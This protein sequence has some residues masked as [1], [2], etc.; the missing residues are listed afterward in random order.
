MFSPDVASHSHS[1][2]P[3]RTRHAAG[4]DDTV[5]L[6]QAKRK[7]SAL[8]RDTFEPLNEA[9][10]NENT[11]RPAAES[12]KAPRDVTETTALEAQ[13]S[14]PSVPSRELTLRGGKKAEKRLER[15]AASLLLSS[16][17]FYTVS[18]LPTLP[19]Q[20]RSSPTLPYACVLSSDNGYAAALSHSDAVIWPYAISSFVPSTRDV[21]TFKLPLPPVSANDPLPLASFTA[22]DASGYPGLVVV[23]PKWGKIVY[24]DSITDASTILPGQSSSGVQGTMPSLAAGEVVEEIINAEPAGY[25]LTTS[26]GRVAH[27]TVRDQVGRPAVGVHFLRKPPS[28]SGGA[29]LGSIRNALIGDRR[30]GTLRVKAGA[31]A[32]GQRTVVVVTEDGD[33]EQWETSLAAGDVVKMHLTLRQVLLD[34]LAPQVPSDLNPTLMHF[35]LLDFELASPEHSLSRRGSVASF[36]IITLVSLSEN[37]RTSYYIIEVIVN[38]AAAQVQV[39]HPI[40]C[41]SDELSGSQTRSRPSLSVSKSQKLAF[42]VFEGAVVLF[43]LAKIEESPTSQ[44]LME[45]H[46]LPDPFQDCIRFQD[47]TIYKVLA[48][49]K[50]EYDQKPALLLAIQGFGI[51]RILSLLQDHDDS[52]DEVLQDTVSAKSKIEQAIFFGTM[53]QNPLDLSRGSEDAF[54]AEEIQLAAMAISSEILAST[55]KYLPKSMPSIDQQMKLRA[56]A[57]NDL[58]SHLMKQYRSK[59]SRNFLYQLLWNAEKLAAAQAIWKVEEEIQRRYPIA[60]RETPYLDFCLYALHESRQKYP[61][62]EKGEKDRVRFWLYNSVEKIA[63]LL[64]ELVDCFRELDDMDV[65][66]PMIVGVYMKEAMDLW[67]AAYTAAF[68]FR[69]DNAQLYGLGDDIFKDGILLAG[70]PAEIGHPWT[71]T[72]EGFQ[73]A[74]RMIIDLIKYMDEWWTFDPNSKEGQKKKMPVNHFD[75]KPHDAPPKT[76]LNDIAAKLPIVTELFNRLVSEQVIFVIRRS[77]QDPDPQSRAEAIA[78]V[79]AKKKPFQTGAILQIRKFNMPGAIEL[80]EKKKDPTLL[81]T[82]TT[83]YLR[84]LTLDVHSGSQHT[85]RYQAKIRETQDRAETYY[86]CFGKGWAY[87]NFRHMIKD[88]QLG[89]LLVTAQTSDNKQTYLTWF[90][91]KAAKCG[92]SLS[93]MSWINDVVGEQNFSRAEKTLAEVASTEEIDVWNTKTELS[94]AKLASLAALE[95]QQEKVGRVENEDTIDEYDNKLTLIDMQEELLKHVDAAIGPALDKKVSEDLAMEIFAARVVD[96]KPGFKKLLR[97]ALQSLLSQQPLTIEEMINALTLSDPV[98]FEGNPEDDPYLLGNEFVWAL[99]A[100]ELSTLSEKYKAALRQVIWRRAMIRDDW[101]ILNNTV[102]KSD[103]DVQNGMQQSSVFRT[104]VQLFEEVALDQ[105]VTDLSAVIQH[106]V[107]FPMQILHNSLFTLNMA[108]RF[109]SDEKVREL[110]KKDFE[111]E[112]RILRTYV[113]K[114]QLDKHFSGLL[115][116]LLTSVSISVIKTYIMLEGMR[117]CKKGNGHRSASDP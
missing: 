36:P 6:P 110:I 109:S 3:K 95:E 67:T 68:K 88:G 37:G 75:G 27:L 116:Y 115:T 111:K 56:K 19:D 61:D 84:K 40:K 104:L 51:I 78:K 79:K 12:F 10:V 39:V 38:E 55:S 20:I 30:K 107:C 60:D 98:S 62:D 26:H 57:L 77:E 17:D 81:V 14:V 106:Q 2:R 46:E 100:V 113:D 22:K 108:E 85:L 18:Q 48:H 21:T 73:Y 105:S 4:T 70:Y 96:K 76:L 28:A 8:R 42:V 9:S 71:S 65:T 41:F 91:E 64:G 101:T 89:S 83:E 44:I 97:G 112:Q 13:P 49:G 34:A 90:F 87:A 114:A 29:F 11:G 58:I 1:H 93:K 80:A 5:S 69:E 50:E 117:V 92:Q 103:Q 24:W 43:S 54:S 7:R 72:E 74:H 59:L 94:L 31:A 32:K 33:L 25:I 15:G 99:R 66:D 63:F 16:N 45:R 86:D 82:L 52:E 102:N 47:D 35:S 53:K 23:S